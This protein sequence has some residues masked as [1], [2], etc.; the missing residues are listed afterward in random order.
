M[1]PRDGLKDSE[2]SNSEVTMERYESYVKLVS[3]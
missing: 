3:K 2:V 1:A